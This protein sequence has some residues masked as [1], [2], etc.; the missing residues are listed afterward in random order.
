MWVMY[1]RN[2]PNNDTKQFYYPSMFHFISHRL[3]S[4]FK[5]IIWHSLKV[6]LHAKDTTNNILITYGHETYFQSPSVITIHKIRIHLSHAGITGL[7]IRHMLSWYKLNFL[8]YALT[9]FN[10][11]VSKL[12]FLIWRLYFCFVTNQGS[13][14]IYPPTFFILSRNITMHVAYLPSPVL[15]WNTSDMCYH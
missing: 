14:I 9:D 15:G 2:V 12:C 4:F 3:L 6:R 10:C 11:K 7:S 8:S 13:V 1:F 5:P